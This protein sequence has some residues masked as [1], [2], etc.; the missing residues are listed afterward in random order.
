MS[1]KYT[2]VDNPEEFFQMMS[3]R[4]DSTSTTSTAR[5]LNNATAHNSLNQT[6]DTTMQPDWVVTKN[7]DTAL[8]YSFLEYNSNLGAGTGGTETRGL[9]WSMGTNASDDET[10]GY[11]S[12]FDS[13]G[14]SFKQG[15]NSNRWY[16]DRG[17]GGGDK[18]MSYMWKVNGGTT[19]SNTSGDTTADVQVNTQAGISIAT[20]TAPSGNTSVGH[21]L[22]AKPDLILVKSDGGGWW[23]RHNGVNMASQP[24]HNYVGLHSTAGGNSVGANFYADANKVYLKSDFMI[25]SN[26]TRMYCFKEI[27]GYSRFYRYEGAGQ[28]NGVFVYTGFKPAFLMYK[29]N[30][31]GYHWRIKDV[32]R[33]FAGNPRIQRFGPTASDG[34]YGGTSGNDYVDFL[35]NGFKFRSNNSDGNVADIQ[36]IYWAFAQNPFVTSS[37]AATTAL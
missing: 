2:G 29:G 18:Y 31:S 7:R 28:E 34:D 32:E 17:E 5:S 20:F 16:F 22:G 24:T 36:Y 10:Y 1:T 13:N 6:S 11:L 9:F 27:Q 19:S 37:G 21:G 15:S 35:S 4:G 23:M 26:A 3:W 12:S 25:S 8:S 30:S 14:F 33:D